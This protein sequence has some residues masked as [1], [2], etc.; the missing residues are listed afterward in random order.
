MTTKTELTGL[1]LRFSD[2]DT[3]REFLKFFDAQFIVQFRA[4]MI[5]GIVLIFIDALVDNFVAPVEA[6]PGN[7]IRLF[8]VEPILLLLLAGSF[9]RFLRAHFQTYVCVVFS[10][11]SIGLLYGVELIAATHAPIVTTWVGIINYFFVIIFAFLIIG[12]R[13]LAGAATGAIVTIG[14]LGVMLATKDLDPARFMYS[15]YHI[16]TIYALGLFLGYVRELYVRRDFAAQRELW[17][18]QESLRAAKEAADRANHAK[19]EFLATMSHELRTPMN[20][21][22]G[23]ARLAVSKH[24]M[25]D[26]LAHLLRTIERSGDVLKR[27]IDD[28]LDITRIEAGQLKMEQEP[29]A[30]SALVEDIVEIVR[31][32]ALE[33]KSKVRWTIAEP[34]PAEVVGDKAHVRQVLLNIVGNAVKFTQNGSIA[35]DVTASAAGEDQIDLAFAVRDTGIGIPSDELQL[36]FEP[37]TQATNTIRG[38]H[39]GTGLGLAIAKRLVT[40]MGGDLRVESELGKGSTFTIDI[41]VRGTT[42]LERPARDHSRHQQ[43]ASTSLSL[44]LVEDEPINQQVAKGLLE[45]DGHEVTVVAS[46]QAALA[47]VEHRRFDAVL[48]DM[49]LPDL[50][51]LEVARRLRQSLG[52][53]APPVIALTANVMPNEV[54]AYYAAGVRAVVGKP[55]DPAKLSQAIGGHVTR[56]RPSTG[57]RVHIPELFDRQQIALILDSFEAGRSVK[58]LLQLEASIQESLRSLKRFLADRQVAEASKSAHRLAGSAVFFGLRAL[59]QTAQ[60]LESSMARED[61]MVLQQRLVDTERSAEAAL[62]AIALLRVNLSDTRSPEAD[63]RLTASG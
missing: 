61:S 30:V 57:S 62:Q 58:L 4:A 26:E 46:G 50:D 11:A 47:A 55:I 10:I 17:D 21:I 48:L 44:L 42:S 14:Y 6:L 22:L 16:V 51:G 56:R 9:T 35:I 41:R 25:T 27:L 38:G 40:A 5:L 59:H 60:E 13:V 45:F 32:L 54:E 1:G 28:V 7:A 33:Q 31:P 37:L 49:R 19:S 39:G 8:F 20:G 34:V 12:L 3:E 53:A 23:M 63:E 52:D 43:A 29:F 36:V 24:S 15:T 2:L 18:R